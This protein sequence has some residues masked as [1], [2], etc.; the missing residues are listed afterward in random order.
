VHKPS[1]AIGDTMVQ[2]AAVQPTIDA[3]DDGYFA[4]DTDCDDTDAAVHPGATEAFNQIDDD[5]DGSIDEGF[6]RAIAPTIQKARSGTRGGPSNAT[7]RWAVP[8]DDGGSAVAH[9]RVQ[10]VKLK[11]S[12]AVVRRTTR[13]AGPSAASLVVR[14]TSGTYKFRVS[15]VN[16]V[17]R[18]T[19]ST[20]SNR[21]TAR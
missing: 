10:A 6:S 15:A 14:L 12:G 20:Y 4:D 19:W 17:G 1:G 3:D 18:S 5:C 9:Y 7:A 8:V 13:L 2:P 16:E 21:V 11:P